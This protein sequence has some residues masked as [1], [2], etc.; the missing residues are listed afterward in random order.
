MPNL[1]SYRF[2]WFLSLESSRVLWR[3]ASNFWTAFSSVSFRRSPW[4]M[5][6]SLASVVNS[7]FERPVS[8]FRLAT[9]RVHATSLSLNRFRKEC[10]ETFSLCP[11]VVMPL[12]W[13]SVVSHGMSSRLYLVQNDVQ[14]FPMARMQN[15]RFQSAKFTCVQWRYQHREFGWSCNI[16]SQKNKTSK[17]VHIKSDQTN[18]TQVKIINFEHIGKNTKTSCLQWRYQQFMEE[19]T[20]RNFKTVW[21]KTVNYCV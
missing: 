3:C 15:C 18:T 1:H 4:L 16:Q 6:S 17:V 20:K 7:R 5:P 8:S 13:S 19:F 14:N 10:R 2:Y 9:W 21:S 12:A 11:Y